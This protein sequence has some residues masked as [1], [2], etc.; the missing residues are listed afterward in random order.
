M[1]LVQECV[2]NFDLPIFG[3]FFLEYSV[4]FDVLRFFGHNKITHQ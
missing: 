2:F 3:F 4:Q 1:D